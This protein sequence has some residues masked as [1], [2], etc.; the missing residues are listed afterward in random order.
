MLL[1]RRAKGGQTGPSFVL[2]VSFLRVP[3]RAVCCQLT[4]SSVKD[5]WEFWETKHQWTVQTPPL[6]SASI[7]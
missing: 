4:T 2:G 7:L 3:S 6:L 5:T 1:L